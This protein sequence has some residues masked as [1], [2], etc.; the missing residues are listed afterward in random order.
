VSQLL[1]QR[2]K[3]GDRPARGRGSA[4]ERGRRNPAATHGLGQHRI[5][6]E[7]AAAGARRLTSTASSRAPIRASCRSSSRPSSNW[8]SISRPRSRSASPCRSPCRRAPT[9][10]SN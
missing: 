8:R 9:R 2:A 4:P 3:S 10:W 7:L 6:Q 1:H 5:A